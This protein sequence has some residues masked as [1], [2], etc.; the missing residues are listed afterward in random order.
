[1][2]RGTRWIRKGE[3]IARRTFG[4]PQQAYNPQEDGTVVYIEITDGPAD[5]TAFFGCAL[6]D[7]LWEGVTREPGC[8]VGVVLCN[9]QLGWTVVI[10]DDP[11][12]LPPAVYQSLLDNVATD[13]REQRRRQ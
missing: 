4:N 7:V 5:W 9:N 6:E 1:M 11:A 10:P 13:D 8:F 2:V 12:Q 3:A